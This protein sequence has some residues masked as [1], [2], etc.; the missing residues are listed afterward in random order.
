MA[1]Q[2]EKI[3]FLERRNAELVTENKELKEELAK[4]GHDGFAE[5]CINYFWASVILAI[6]FVIGTVY[7]FIILLDAI[8]SIPAPIIAGPLAIVLF[9]GWLTYVLSYSKHLK[10]KDSAKSTKT[11]T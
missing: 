8:A 1:S 6:L 2:A 9:G 4:R 7:L 5:W 11:T 3:G 10:D